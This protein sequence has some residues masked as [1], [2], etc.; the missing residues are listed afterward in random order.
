MRRLLFLLLLLVVSCTNPYSSIDTPP[1]PR[2]KGD[3]EVISYIDKRLEEEYYWLDEVLERRAYF[4]RSLSWD[5]YL[6]HA[7]SRLRTNNDDGYFNSQGQ[8]G[9][10]SYIREIGSTTRAE[11]M[12]FGIALHYT[13]IV[14]DSENRRYGFV[15]ESVYPGSPAEMA[16][17]QRGDI[18]TMVDSR[19]LDSSNYVAMFNGIVANSLSSVKI[20][21]LRRSEGKTSHTV[22]LNK[23]AYH[24]TPVVYSDIIELE[25]YDKK[26]G[27]LVYTSFESEY[28]QELMDVLQGFATAGIGE[29]IL[30]L[31]CNGGGAL[32]SAVK[33]C[34][35]LV[36]RGYECQML[37]SI[38]RN[39][40][41]KKFGINSYNRS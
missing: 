31:R 39:K 30:D 3:S 26:I 13:I 16:G 27:Y 12:G 32:Y 8:R 10:Y 14:M 20:E 35:A 34:S 22:T 18:I 33:L 7:L 40:N 23:G 11:V 19:Y 21:Y 37:C 4:D 17:M 24:E 9:Y 36:P 38:K 29:L 25:G 2:P 41:N 1:A 6:P 15:I 5:K 28:D